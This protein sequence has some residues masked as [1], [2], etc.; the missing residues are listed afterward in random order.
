MRGEK[1]FFRTVC[2]LAIPAALQ[3]L[4]Q[5]SF[6]LVDQ[7]MIGQLGAVSVAAVGLAGK[8][9]SIYA[10]VIAAIGA[11]AGIMISQYL[12]QNAPAEVRRSF[13][14][15]LWLGFGLAGAFTALCLL[16]PGAIMRAYT[17]DVQT[18]QT[19]AGVIVGKRLGSGDEDAAYAAGK[20][21]L[22]YGAAGAALLSVLVVLL[23][24]V[25]VEIYQ[26]EDGVKRLTRQ[27]LTAYALVAPCKV[28][29]MILGGGILRSGGRTAY[30]MAIDLVG[31]W[32]FGVPAGL[33]T[34]FVFALPVPY[35]YFALSLEECLRFGI[36]LAVFRRRRWMRRLSA[37]A[38]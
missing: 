20:R 11:V 33:V 36:S 26:V 8:F 17:A 1:R 3:S 16:C 13:F 24:G 22:V 2:T 25:Y 37:H 32:G 23:S 31:T 28:L 14:T 34:A 5:S 38:D 21:L 35:V 30:V 7:I 12:G 27:I 19:A 29:N 15:N 4:L 10:V 9:A 18:L 6:S